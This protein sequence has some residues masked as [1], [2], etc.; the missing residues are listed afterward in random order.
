M[1][2]AFSSAIFL[3]VILQELSIFIDESGNDG[4]KSRYY[5]LTLVLHKQSDSFIENI[6]KYETS[7]FDRQ[8]PNI[9]F[10]AT[11]LLN[12]HDD[13][14][15]LDLS[16]RKK[17]LSAFRV[18]VRYIP[19]R[20]TCITLDTREFKSLDDASAAMR[21]QL[22][23]FMFDHLTFLQTFDHVKIYYDNGQQSIVNA[24]HAAVEY[25]IAKE[26]IIYKYASPSD[27]RLS[28]VADYICTM[29]LTELKYANKQSTATD[30]K[31][32]GTWSKF[33]KGIFKDLLAKRI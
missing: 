13:Y 16:T 7:L 5:I 9:P 8:L 25:A 27:Y 17:L 32:F 11:P 21:K 18:F 28:Q 2:G 24:I 3:G 12:G 20:Y 26:A 30:N 6:E 33:K 15:G 22:I 4:L 29:E 31:F 23:D 10:H 1:P 14:R 19:I